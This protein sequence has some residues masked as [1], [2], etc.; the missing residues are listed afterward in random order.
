MEAIR[1]LLNIVRI[2]TNQER[3]LELGEPQETSQNEEGETDSFLKTSSARSSVKSMKTPN[4]AP[5]KG[6]IFSL[7]PPTSLNPL[8][9]QKPETPLHESSESSIASIAEDV[10]GPSRA[11]PKPGKHI[12]NVSYQLKI[13]FFRNPRKES[14]SNQ[15]DFKET[16]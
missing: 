13:L 7:L 10:P 4:A 8:L 3:D 15:K 5:K 6:E 2:V 12:N 14:H 16:R 11:I 1:S 9:E